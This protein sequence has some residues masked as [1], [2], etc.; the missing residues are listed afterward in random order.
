MK[1]ITTLFIGFLISINIHAQTEPLFPEMMGA[2]TIDFPT[3]NAASLGKYGQIPVS[4]YNGLVNIS[5]PIYT[6]KLQD[7]EVPIVLQY[8]SGGNKTDEHPG[9]VGLGWNL[10]A[11]GSIEL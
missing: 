9:W 2:K 6:I 3:P 1:H 5:I 7:I 4:Y 11:G 10:Q 8:H